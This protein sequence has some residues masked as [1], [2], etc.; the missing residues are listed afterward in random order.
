MLRGNAVSW[1]WITALPSA[2]INERVKARF[3]ATDFSARA[4]DGDDN[5]LLDYLF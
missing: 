5:D 2:S 1:Q 3:D 4:F